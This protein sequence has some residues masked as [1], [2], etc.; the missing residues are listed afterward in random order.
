MVRPA[1]VKESNSPVSILDIRINM[2]QGVFPSCGTCLI[3]V[4]SYNV[5][6]VG[7][8]ALQFVYNGC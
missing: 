1:Q 4:S 3:T 8:G 7:M 2:V 5:C 6:T